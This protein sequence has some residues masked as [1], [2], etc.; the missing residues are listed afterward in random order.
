MGSSLHYSGKYRESASL[1]KMID[2][3][4]D[5]VEVCKWKYNIG[6]QEMRTF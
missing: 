6:K 1:S 2:E 3:V 4:K 5:I